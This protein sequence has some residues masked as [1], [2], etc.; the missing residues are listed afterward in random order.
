MV[1]LKALIT[2][3]GEKNY[4]SGSLRFLF[5]MSMG[6]IRFSTLIVD[7]KMRFSDSVLWAIAI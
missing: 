4:S 2:S 7:M 5:T 6:L 1:K 3:M